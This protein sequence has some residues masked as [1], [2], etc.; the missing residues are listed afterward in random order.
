MKTAQALGYRLTFALLAW[1]AM[2]TA[3]LAVTG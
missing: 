1:F 2:L 3:V